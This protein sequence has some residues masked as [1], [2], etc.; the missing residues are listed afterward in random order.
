MHRTFASLIRVAIAFHCLSAVA[1][2]TSLGSLP[3]ANLSIPG[4]SG[5]AHF[6][7]TTIDGTGTWT[8]DNQVEYAVFAPG[9]FNDSSTLQGIATQAALDAADASNGANYVYTY[10]IFNLGSTYGGTSNVN[11]TVLSVDL[12]DFAIPPGTPNPTNLAI[13]SGIAPVGALTKFNGPYPQSNVLFGF[14][15]T[16]LLPDKFSNILI[17]TSPYGPAWAD[18]S[19]GGQQTT[20]ADLLLALPTPVPEPAT[21]ALAVIG[22]ASLFATRYLRRR[23]R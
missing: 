2:A 20:H 15:A 1:W 16:T 5:T 4:W 18:A 21:S 13:A 11:A 3:G 8:L 10:Q 6:T 17:F 14:S 22:I 7:A 9:D 12:N 23:F 19:T